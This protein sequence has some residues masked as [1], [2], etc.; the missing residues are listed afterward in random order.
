MAQHQHHHFYK[1]GFQMA[2]KTSFLVS[3]A[4]TGLLAASGYGGMDVAQAGGD[5]AL[6]QCA[7]IPAKEKA[8][9]NSQKRRAKNSKMDNGRQCPKKIIERFFSFS[10][11]CFFSSG[12]E[13]PNI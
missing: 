11:P 12:W 2:N 7:R 6:G 4:I 9:S 1:E 8:G 10:V 3:A 13:S 5:H